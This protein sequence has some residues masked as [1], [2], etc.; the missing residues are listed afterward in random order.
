MGTPRKMKREVTPRLRNPEQGI[1]NCFWLPQDA[2]RGLYVPN[3]RVVQTAGGLYLKRRVECVAPVFYRDASLAIVLL[4]ILLSVVPFH[5]GRALWYL[6]VALWA[7][8]LCR[9]EGEDQGSAFIPHLHSIAKKFTFIF[10][11]VPALAF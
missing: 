6:R 7:S 10:Q 8:D 2:Y 5:S 11:Q 9:W 1:I 3:V 4:R